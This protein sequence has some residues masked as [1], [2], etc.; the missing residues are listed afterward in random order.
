MVKGPAESIE[1]L[2]DWIKAKDLDIEHWAPGSKQRFLRITPETVTGR[3]IQRQ[4]AVRPSC[5]IN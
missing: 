5:L 3:V 2:A 4:G 1:N